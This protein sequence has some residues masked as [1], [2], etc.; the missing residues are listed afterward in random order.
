M[1]AKRGTHGALGGAVPL[2]KYTSSDY[3]PHVKRRRWVNE[4]ADLTID[5]LHNFKETFMLPKFYKGIHKP[6]H[7]L[8]ARDDGPNLG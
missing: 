4:I 1:R 5:L 7:S 8:E 3:F 6:W 2:A